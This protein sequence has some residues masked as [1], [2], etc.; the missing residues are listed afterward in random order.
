MGIK[1]K[2]LSKADLFLIY[3]V[4]NCDNEEMVDLRKFMKQ[5]EQCS[6]TEHTKQHSEF[7]ILEQLVKCVQEKN[8]SLL[9][10]FAFFDTN[11][12]G[13]ITR[14]EFIYA[15]NQ[16]GFTASDENINRLIYIVS[17]E[18]PIDTEI[19]IHKLDNQDNFN[20]IEF[21]ELFE[22]KS[23]NLILKNRRT[24][25]N[26][27]KE[28]IDWRVNLLTKIYNAMNNSHLNIEFAFD[29]FDKTE[30][31]FLNLVE[32]SSFLDYIGMKINAE[33][34]KKLFLSFN[35]DYKINREI[36][37]K[38]YYVPIDKIKE[39]LHKVIL[40]ANEYKRISE[41]LFVDTSKKID[42]N[43]KYNLLLEEQ[44]YYN[45]KYND[46]EKRY[47]DLIKNNQ[48]LTIQ[49]QDYVK[50]NN[51]NIDKYFNAIEELQQIKL[52]YISTGVRREDYVKMQID[53]DSLTR[54]VNILRIG[55]NTFKE[56]YNTSNFQAKQLHYNEMRN[57]DEL[58]T[59]KKAIRELQGESNKNNLIGKLYYTIL[60]CRWREAST[61]KKYDES[62]TNINQMKSDN[63]ALEKTNKDLT[64]NLNDIQ[65]N[66]HEKII[67]NIRI[68]DALE[69][70]ERGIEGF[71][72]N[73]EK[74][75]P[76]EEMKKLVN[77]LKD[78]KKKNTEQLLI[79]KKKVF[80]LENEKDYLEN[81]IDFC[82]NLANNIKFNNRDEYSQKL[83]G[84]S[85]DI[86]KL[87][88]NNKQ[89]KRENNF[90]KENKEHTERLNEQLNHNLEEFEKKNAEWEAKYRK[91]QEIYHK[92]DEDRQNKIIEG[93]ENMK[94]YKPG[95][96]KSFIRN[97]QNNNTINNINDKNN[98]KVNN[99]KIN[100]ENHKND[101]DKDNRNNGDEDDNNEDDDD[102]NKFNGN[103]NKDDESSDYNN[104]SITKEQ[105][106]KIALN[107]EKIKQLN[108]IINKK[109]EEINRLNK[110]NEE[111][112]NA[113]K[114]GK[115]FLDTITVEKLVGKGGYNI[116]KN[117]ENQLMAKTIHQTVKTMQE[118]I[119]QKNTELNYKNKVIDKL[120]DEL[121]K[122][123][124]ISLQKINILEDQLKDKHQNN[125]NKLQKL[126]E[127]NK[128]EIPII[129]N[130]NEL[131]LTTLTEFEK[132]IADKDNIIRSLEAEL[133]SVKQD[134]NN[135]YVKLSEK[136][137]TIIDLEDKIKMLKLNQEKD[138]NMELINQ[139]KRE[140]DSK[141][142]M[143]EI[144]K[145][146]I[147]ELKN[148]FMK[149]YQDKTLMDNEDAQ[150]QKHAHSVQMAE[151]PPVV[152]D[153]EKNELKKQNQKLKTQIYK[154]N[155]EKKKLNKAI[156]DLENSKNEVNLELSKIKNDKKQILELQIKDNKK[157]SVLNKEKEKLKK[158][159]NRI[160]EEL[161][162]M[163][164]RLNFIEQ[165]NQKLS[166]LNNSFEQELKSRPKVGAR[167]PSAKKED[168][169]IKKKVSKKDLN[170][171]KQNQFSMYSS[172]GYWGST[173]EL[174]NNIC[175]YCVKKN[176]NLKKHLRRYDISKNG[177]IGEND[178]KRAIE[179]LKL[180]F[181][182]AD[183]DK[184]VNTCKSP[185]SK[186][187]SID[188]FLNILK[189]KN[190]SF[191]KFIEQLPEVPDNINPESKQ[192][193]KKYDK[194]ENKAFNIDY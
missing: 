10:A 163:R 24:N 51:S 87:K 63:F 66:L 150:S 9:E 115:D 116:I 97:K 16:L 37:P 27:N 15:L 47:N 57:L 34:L 64:K 42:I 155:E 153:Q 138:F 177:K 156:E 50:Q 111:N 171:Q 141:N 43:L 70:Y 17:G 90:I 109:D 183:L 92:R 157:I 81:E 187:I 113:M 151:S 96:L 144:E 8:Q 176:V 139:L 12:H 78:D 172:S 85:E 54:E 18:N 175:E 40:I 143:I 124:S 59:Y 174:L 112:I 182:N 61:L 133:K 140:I 95:K 152:D 106:N 2:D 86:A 72:P 118:M 154:F 160:K 20:Y 180:G 4:L 103:N 33:T 179:E 44:K 91:M 93:L 30:K 13:C 55:M 101:E 108:E 149:N 147:D 178:F 158:D 62:L 14:E 38:N 107:E 5:I 122:T 142:K 192:F 102:D 169:K 193:S 80:S 131:S 135:N 105:L 89:L 32:F 45:L 94:I 166:A 25:L 79:L 23:K 73:K 76:M 185:Y 117:E 136:N 167:P 104:I 65:N 26:K 52:E 84:M 170:Q 69:N 184:L 145:E 130:K 137:K 35:H 134:N 114:K 162:Q 123:K 75:Y 56:L 168:Q 3:K 159:N 125:L 11:N 6:I 71:T 21:C 82:E 31:G 68:N 58:D 188:N 67:E 161:E 53:N 128:N 191:K 48:L 46:L 1:E 148:N 7:Q 36:E 120:R 173:D 165:E 41:M 28:L 189:N 60:I 132:L 49:L 39:E 126:L 100:N 74:I 190:E 181:I 127:E 119:K 146:K 121:S 164:I 77:M 29:S 98:N 110:L 186:D 22:Q 194:F 88:L 129:K 19:N 83:I 99:P